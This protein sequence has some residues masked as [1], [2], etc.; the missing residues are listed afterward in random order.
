MTAEQE[1][2]E[3]R[4]ALDAGN[5]TLQ[6]LKQARAE[7][8]SASNFGVADMLGFDLIGGI[9]KHMKINKAKAQ[10]EEAKRQVVLFQHEL[11]DVSVRLQFQVNIGDFLTF[12]DFLFDGIFTDVIVQSKISDA[13]EQ[14]DRAIWQVEQIINDLY[15]ME[16]E[17]L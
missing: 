10:L 3:I 17:V 6:C 8:N 5:R 16:R 9:G 14:V 12:A 11:K 7:L 2:R 15:R 1:L 13:K 4:E